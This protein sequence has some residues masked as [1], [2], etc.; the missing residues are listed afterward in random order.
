LRV[1]PFLQD[2]LGC[3]GLREASTFSDPGRA[4]YKGFRP[5]F[6]PIHELE[7]HISKNFQD[8]IDQSGKKPR[9]DIRLEPSVTGPSTARSR[10]AER[11][12]GARN[13][14]VS[15]PYSGVYSIDIR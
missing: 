9:P 1:R 3:P 15:T 13:P 5:R 2:V 11:N 7:M 4:L 14:W 6:S 12:N 8:G 10:V